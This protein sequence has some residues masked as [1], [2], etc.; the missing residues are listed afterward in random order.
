MLSQS[1]NA[2]L[3]VALNINAAALLAT[4]MADDR[5]RNKRRDACL[6]MIGAD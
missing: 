3:P 1:A 6:A 4:T 2:R 5:R